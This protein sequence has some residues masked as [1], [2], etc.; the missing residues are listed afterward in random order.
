MGE[1]PKES[2]VH[3]LSRIH[4]LFIPSE[5][6]T[7][8][9]PSIP[10]YHTAHLSI[11]DEARRKWI[12]L[13]ASCIAGTGEFSFTSSH[14]PQQEKSWAEKVSL[15]TELCSLGGWVIYVNCNCSSHPFQISLLQQYA[16]TSPLDST[17]LLPGLPQNYLIH[18]WWSKLMFFRRNMVENSYSTVMMISSNSLVTCPCDIHSRYGGNQISFRKMWFDDIFKTRI[19]K[20]TYSCKM[21]L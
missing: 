6:P 9:S 2:K 14:F 21:Y 1:F 12:S 3:A 19:L 10:H 5:S 8:C 7:C 17:R 11:L 20:S 16:G 4:I 18:G 13:A 15:G